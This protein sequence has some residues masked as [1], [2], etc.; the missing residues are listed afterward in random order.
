MQIDEP[1]KVFSFP[2]ISTSSVDNS[3]ETFAT[4]RPDWSGGEIGW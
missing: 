1:K 3:I 2:E 4:S